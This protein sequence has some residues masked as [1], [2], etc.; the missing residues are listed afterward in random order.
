MNIKRKPNI[1]PANMGKNPFI[2]NEIIKARS[3]SKEKHYTIQTDDKINLVTGNLK[4]IMLVEEQHCTKLFHDVD[5]R[6]IIL[7][8]DENGMRLFL[9]IMYQINP[10]EDY[11]WINN[12]H[13][14]SLTNVSKKQY[15]EGIQN[16]IRY[17]II[18]T[19]I[20]QEVYFINP[21]IFF[22]GNRLKKYPDNIKVRL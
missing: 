17:S 6:N 16:L 8:L 2:V 22:S 7:K 12:T 20:Y 19:T 14:Q 3:F 18:T 11:V 5:Y 21:M 1:I 15:L 13:Y 9:Y 4:E 10:N